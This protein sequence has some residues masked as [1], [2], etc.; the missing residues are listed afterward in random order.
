MSE[1]IKYTGSLYTDDTSSIS[2]DPSIDLASLVK[3]AKSSEEKK[4]V[5][6]TNQ[7]KIEK[8]LSPLEQMR[9]EQEKNGSGMIISNEELEKGKEKTDFVNSVYNENRIHGIEEK[10]NELDE[11]MEKRKAIVPIQH[12]EIHSPEYAEM[13]IEINSVKFKDDGTAY[14]DLKDENGDLIT[15]KYIR[16]RTKEDPEYTEDGDKVESQDTANPNE[17]DN[18]EDEEAEEKRK[19]VEILIDKTG[20]GINYDFTEEER[21][22]IFES[23]EIRLKEVELMDIESITM[24]KTDVS[25]Q[26]KIHEF[27]LFNSKTTICFPASGFRAQMKG[28]TYGEMGDVSLSMDSVTFDQ[29]YKRLTI[30]YNKMTNISV[31]PFNSFEDFLKG[32]AYVDIPMALYGLYISTQPEIQQIELRCGSANCNKTFDWSFATRSVLRL[33]NCSTVF[34]EK[35]KEITQAPAV[36][37]DQIRKN[38]AVMKSK[39]LKLP[40]SKFIVEMGIISAYDFL[41]NFIPVLDEKTFRDAF[42][43]DINNVYVNNLLLLTSIRSVRVPDGKGGYIL[44]VGYKDIL[45]A[46][47]NI[48]PEE[49]KLLASVANKV[50][51]DYQVSFSFQNIKCPHCGNITKDLDVTMDDLVFQTYQR[52]LNTEINVENILGL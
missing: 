45:D 22:K 27:E 50:T 30:I 34:L 13:M 1:E 35:M 9:K 52:L 8:T 49:I 10:M 47:Y 7:S 33:E 12:P 42:G 41:Y 11:M 26:E 19:I 38:S 21:E 39:Y 24:A 18:D 37:Y 3:K 28:M 23:Q 15:P 46:I 43:D 31:G 44:C 14:I 32:F 4:T 20:L 40:Y 2:R 6:P 29:Y 25:F 5:S 16:L 17:T 36:E 51:G 48:S